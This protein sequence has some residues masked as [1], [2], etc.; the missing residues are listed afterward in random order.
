MATAMGRELAV[1]ARG[2]APDTVGFP[3][4]PLAPMRLHRFS[5]LGARLAIQYLRLRDALDRRA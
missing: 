2:A 4:T 3:V 5:R 1:W